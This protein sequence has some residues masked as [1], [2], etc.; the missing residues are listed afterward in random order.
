MCKPHLFP[1]EGKGMWEVSKAG[2]AATEI[3]EHLK[4]LLTNEFL[5]KWEK[6]REI[7]K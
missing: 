5:R 6:T 7:C 4:P 2:K 3:V 1:P